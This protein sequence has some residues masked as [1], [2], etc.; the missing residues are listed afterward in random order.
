[1]TK[2]KWPTKKTLDKTRYISNVPE[3]EWLAGRLHC[4]A[5]SVNQ[6]WKI[7]KN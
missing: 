3:G 1:M 7:R 5:V 4:I 6:N 2:M